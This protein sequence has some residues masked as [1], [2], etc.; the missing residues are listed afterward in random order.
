MTDDQ[1]IAALLDELY[2]LVSGPGSRSRNWARQAELFLPQARMIRTVI[3]A[4]GRARPEI[5]LVEEYPE[6]YERLMRGRDF[7]EVEISRIVERFG[8]IAH[9]FSSY[10]AY[11]DAGRTRLVKRGINSIQLYKVDGAWRIAAMVWDDERPGQPIPE[12]YRVP[13]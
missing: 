6:S 2:A 12:R 8:Q 9:A 4:E 13:G 3:D 10:E 11:A 5:L 1:A 7:F